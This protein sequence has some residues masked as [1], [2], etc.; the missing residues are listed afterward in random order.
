MSGTYPIN[1]KHAK[2][3]PVLKS[4]GDY[5]PIAILC[6]LL[7]VLEK[8]LY[9]QMMNYID[10]NNFLSRMQ[11]GIRPG[12]SCI[13]ALVDVIENVRQ[14]L[15]NDVNFLVLLDHSEAFDTVAYS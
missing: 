12:H 15:E 2:I 9:M 7:N 10:L 13:N 8:I 11:S 3:V 4:N 1:W 6:F 14:T 5:R